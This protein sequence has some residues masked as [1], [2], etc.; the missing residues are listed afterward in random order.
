MLSLSTMFSFKTWCQL[1]L[2][3]NPYQGEDGYL[4]EILCYPI[5]NDFSRHKNVL[6]LYTN[7][8]KSLMVHPNALRQ[9]QCL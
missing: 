7:A 8:S 1:F 4:I 3:E 2:R 9:N 5:L 6:F